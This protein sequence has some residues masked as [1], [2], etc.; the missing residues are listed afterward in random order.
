VEVEVGET[1]WLPEVVFDPLQAPDAVH[2]VALVEDQVRVDELPDVMD[3]GLAEMETVVA[4]VPPAT[5][6]ASKPVVQ[7]PE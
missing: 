6:N 7:L 3:V 4:G 5:F 2:E 1:D